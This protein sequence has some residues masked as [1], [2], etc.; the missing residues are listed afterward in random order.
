MEWVLAHMEDADF[1][2]P[3]PPRSAPVPSGGGEPDQ[4]A[5]APA[6]ESLAML[7]SMGFSQKEVSQ[8][9]YRRPETSRPAAAFILGRSRP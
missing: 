8:F 5:A 6:P 7:E 1:N 2:D 9:W 3:L 4:A